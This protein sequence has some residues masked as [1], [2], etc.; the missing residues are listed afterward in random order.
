MNALRFAD[1]NGWRQALLAA[2]SAVALTA[3]SQA[4]A[5]ASQAQ[6]NA[7]IT[8]PELASPTHATGAALAGIPY[9]HKDLFCTRGIRTTAGSK[10]LSTFVPPYDATVSA[11]LADAGAVLIAKSNMDEFAMGSSN[12]NSA[13]GAVRNPWDSDR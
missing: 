6:L 11:R 13:F 7:C 3:S 2:P 4:M 10:M 5:R 8:L 12:E 1:I 9:A